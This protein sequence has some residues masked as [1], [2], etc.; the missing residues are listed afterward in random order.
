MQWTKCN[1]PNS[2][3]RKAQ[4]VIA[5]IALIGC[6]SVLVIGNL[7]F[8]VSLFCSDKKKP[9]VGRG[10]QRQRAIE[11]ERCNVEMQDL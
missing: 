4:V 3:S 1:N 8:A 6:G 5:A 7:L 11:E 9:K 10:R 2:K